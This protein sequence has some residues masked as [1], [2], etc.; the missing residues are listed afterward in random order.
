MTVLI[1]QFFNSS[2]TIHK[3]IPCVLLA[4]ADSLIEHV[5]STWRQ[6][7]ASGIHRVLEDVLHMCLCFLTSVYSVL[8]S[9][10]PF[11]KLQTERKDRYGIA[12]QYKH[13]LWMQ[14][15][16]TPS[17]ANRINFISRRKNSQ[18]I[19]DTVI[20]MYKLHVLNNSF[21]GQQ[22]LFSQAIL[23]RIINI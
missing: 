10:N 9:C 15:W 17:G 12:P 19:S 8:L 11:I 21:I 3:V 4:T 20:Y 5:H 2:N 23:L 1:F 7:K 16:C 6:K 18:F 13:N 22:P 14:D